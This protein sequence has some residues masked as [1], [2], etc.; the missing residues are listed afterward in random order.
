MQ[1]AAHPQSLV[2]AFAGVPPIALLDD[3]ITNC[4]VTDMLLIG[5]N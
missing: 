1:P 2:S 5:V 4:V 3:D